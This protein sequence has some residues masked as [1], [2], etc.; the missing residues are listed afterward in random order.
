MLQ[1]S[2][3]LISSHGNPS[4]VKR[5]SSFWLMAIAIIQKMTIEN[6]NYR[7]SKENKFLIVKKLFNHEENK[8][9]AEQVKWG[10]TFMM[11]SVSMKNSNA[12]YNKSDEY[13]QPFKRGIVYY[14]NT[15]YWQR[16]YNQW[17]DSAM[18]CASD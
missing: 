7:G 5:F 17:K 18:Y 8:S 14:V 11:T 4:L 15:K 2:W 12:P 13:H 6:K 3:N 1:C 9:C 16:R 10:K